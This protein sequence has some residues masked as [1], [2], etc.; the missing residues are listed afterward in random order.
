MSIWI[1]LFYSLC[2][3]KIIASDYKNSGCKS[4]RMLQA[5]DGANHILNIE[6][7]CNKC[8]WWH[9]LL[10]YLL[11]SIESKGIAILLRVMVKIEQTAQTTYC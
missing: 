8:T 7:L 2:R 9:L 5:D 1:I 4:D 10:K 3:L 6:G 11:V